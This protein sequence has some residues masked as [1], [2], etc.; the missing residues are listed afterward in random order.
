MDS[1]ILTGVIDSIG[2]TQQVTEKFQKREFVL[3]QTWDSRWGEQENFVDFQLVQQRCGLIDPFKVGQ[4]V[5]VK[6]DID[7]NKTEKYG[8]ISNHNVY[9][10]DAAEAQERTPEAQEKPKT[11]AQAPETSQKG[12]SKNEPEKSNLDNVDDLP[13][14][15]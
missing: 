9:Q 7:G 10:I 15:Q 2:E 14:E 6:F 12:S 8:V 5:T 1:L 11:A 4:K 13:W 3:K